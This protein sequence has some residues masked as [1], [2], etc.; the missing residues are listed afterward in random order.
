MRWLVLP[1]VTLTASAAA[2]RTRSDAGMD[3]D[4]GAASMQAPRR[5][6]DCDRERL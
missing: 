3:V 2:A 6:F 1:G 5:P 4:N